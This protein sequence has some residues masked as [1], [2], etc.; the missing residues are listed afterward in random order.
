[1]LFFIFVCMYVSFIVLRKLYNFYKLIMHVGQILS[2][3]NI[4]QI[5]STYRFF[6]SSFLFPS[7]FLAASSWLEMTIGATRGSK[8]APSLGLNLDS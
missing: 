1:M 2:F 6:S 4:F 3:H 5:I 8:V 7:F